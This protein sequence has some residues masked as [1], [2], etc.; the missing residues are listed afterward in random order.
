MRSRR[1]LSSSTCCVSARPS[2]HG[3]AA[4]LDRGERRGAGAAVVAGNQHDV[5]VRLGHAGR[6]GAD[7]DFGDE[8][9]VHAG[10]R[11]RVLQVEDQL[12]E[13]FDRI[14]VVMRRRRQQR[15]AGRGVP[16]LRDP[17]IDLGPGQLPAFA[18][19]GP[20]GHLD[21]QVVGVD[22]IFAGD[23]EARRGDLLDR[24]PA[25]VAVRIR[26]GCAPDPR[27]PRPCST[28]RQ[29]GSSRSRSSRALP[30]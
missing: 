9:H 22:E 21:L 16:H 19:L 1:S 25:R 11:I 5:A 8:L 6:N 29:A 3:D 4:V 14:D 10:D 20:L 27:R 15:H 30:G 26:A 13:V 24:A 17:R 28:W 23:A 2:S 12:R 18:R 7:A